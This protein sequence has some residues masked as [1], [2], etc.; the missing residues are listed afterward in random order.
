MEATKQK[1][2]KSLYAKVTD[3]GIDPEM[4]AK[5]LNIDWD[6]AAEIEDAGGGDDPEVPSAV[7]CFLLSLS[8]WY[9]CLAIFQFGRKFSVYHD[10]EAVFVQCIL[11]LLLLSLK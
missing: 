6:S 11:E 9:L 8:L 10:Y 5:R 2:S 1:P 7:V 3:T 4:A